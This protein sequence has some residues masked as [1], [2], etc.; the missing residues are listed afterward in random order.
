[1]AGAAV[2]LIFLDA[3]RDDPFK[4]VAAGTASKPGA[5]VAS[6]TQAK[7]PGGTLIGYATGPGQTASDGKK[8]G[9]R[10]YTKA[11]LDNIAKPGVEIQ[12]AMRLVR[13]QLNDETNKAQM[14]WGHSDLTGEVH[15]KPVAASPDASKK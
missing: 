6:A 9:H 13:A 3:S 15:L 2:R 8:G 4:N 7:T 12:Q 10:P 11:L 5:P 1:M 14:A